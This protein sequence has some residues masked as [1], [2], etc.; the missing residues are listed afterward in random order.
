LIYNLLWY[1]VRET[2]KNAV[3]I[4]VAEHNII[5]VTVTIDPIRV[6]IHGPCQA[7]TTLQLVCA[8][9]AGVYVPLYTLPSDT[10]GVVTSFF[11]ILSPLEV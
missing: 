3:P 10:T 9:E 11:V 5:P 1:G 2:L 6:N 7:F 8:T 4:T